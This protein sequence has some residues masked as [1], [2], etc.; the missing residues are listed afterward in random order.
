MF[1]QCEVAVHAQ[2]VEKYLTMGN[3]YISTECED[4]TC[5]EC[6]KISNNGSSYICTECEKDFKTGGA[7]ISACNVEKYLQ[8]ETSIYVQIVKMLHNGKKIFK[9]IT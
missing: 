3:S 9:Q 4:Y 1:W 2:N 6:G 8:Q 5:T 7:H